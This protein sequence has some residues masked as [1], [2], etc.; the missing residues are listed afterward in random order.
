MKRLEF[1]MDESIAE[2]F[3]SHCEELG[4]GSSYTRIDNVT[5]KGR[6]NPR[7]GDSVWPQLNTWIMIVCPDSEVEVFRNI[8]DEIRLDFPSEG[9]FF[10]CTDCELF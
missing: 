4:V 1:I 8:V 2:D 5:G 3:F 6:L 7:M 9:L 10:C